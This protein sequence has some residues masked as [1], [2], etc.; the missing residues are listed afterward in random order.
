VG[1]G[2]LGSRRVGTEHMGWRT[3]VRLDGAARVAFG[4]KLSVQDLAKIVNGCMETRVLVSVGV[5][6]NDANSI[7][8]SGCS[9]SPRSVVGVLGRLTA[10]GRFS[11]MTKPLMLIQ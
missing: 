9:R 7:L 1:P 3:R 6:H 5:W 4:D 2:R 8:Q 10:I 11:R